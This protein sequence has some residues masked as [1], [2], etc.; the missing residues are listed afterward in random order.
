M[1]RLAA[2]TVACPDWPLDVALPHFAMWGYEGVEIRTFGAGDSRMACEPALTDPAKIRG[3]CQG[4][5]LDIASIATSGRYDGRITPPIIGQIIGDPGACIRAT[6]H[7][8]DLAVSLEAPIVRVFAFEIPRR[9]RRGAALRRITDRLRLVCDHARNNQ[10]RIALQNGGSFAGAVELAELIDR[11]DSPL[12]GAA[13]DVATG[14]E[15]DDDPAEAI[16]TLGS[17]LLQARL[18]DSQDG[19]PVAPGEGESQCKR[20][21]EALVEA[22]F[23]GWLIYEWP[24]LFLPEIVDAKEALPRAVEA[25][26][27][28][29]AQAGAPAE[30][31]SASA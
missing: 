11:V 20:F 16:S 6:K 8:I 31:Q 12:L 22:D 17:R 30:T 10:V 5:G 23:D 26:Y 25:V 18:S 19:S 3:V 13:Y 1:F 14:V 15:V 9:E 4:H 2:S 29:L 7:D 24:R 21:V 27:G 28:W